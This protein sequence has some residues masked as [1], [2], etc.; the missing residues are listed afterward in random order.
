MFVTLLHPYSCFIISFT[1]P[2]NVIYIIS[3][4]FVSGLL[5]GIMFVHRSFILSSSC[6]DCTV[7][8]K[9]NLYRT[10]KELYNLQSNVHFGKRCRSLRGLCYACCRP[11][12]SENKLMMSKDWEVKLHGV[13][14]VVNK[15]NCRANFRINNGFVSHGM[16]LYDATR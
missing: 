14:S 8:F 6:S 13:S 10:D 4:Q 11:L 9:G 5:F 15:R 12:R 1:T 3:F 16:V 2:G 7:C